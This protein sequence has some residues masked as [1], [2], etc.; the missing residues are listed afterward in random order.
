MKPIGALRRARGPGGRG[1]DFGARRKS[2]PPR[3]QAAHESCLPQASSRP[4]PASIRVGSAWQSLLRRLWAD[5]LL[6]HCHQHMGAAA[7]P[8]VGTWRLE[9]QAERRIR[10]G[11]LRGGLALTPHGPTVLDASESPEPESHGYTDPT[12]PCQPEA[13]PTCPLPQDD[14][15]GGGRRVQSHRDVRAQAGKIGSQD[16]ESLAIFKFCSDLVRG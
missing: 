16:L 9:Q 1:A 3:V 6:S 15:G 4:L 5:S 10:A 11:G 2:Q 8:R 14:Q 7:R 13:Q 12:A